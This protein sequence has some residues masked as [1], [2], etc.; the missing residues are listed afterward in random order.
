M[1]RQIRLTPYCDSVPSS[2][3]RAASQI[4]AGSWWPFPLTLGGLIVA[5]VVWALFR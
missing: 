1:N 2:A 3:S 5:L 4:S